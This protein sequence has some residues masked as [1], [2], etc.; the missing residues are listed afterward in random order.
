MYPVSMG[1]KLLKKVTIMDM[2]DGAMPADDTQAPATMPEEGAA[3]ET[4]AEGTE[5]QA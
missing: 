1:G 4:A 2:N 3:D 5:A